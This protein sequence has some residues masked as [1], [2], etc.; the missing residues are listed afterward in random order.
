MACTLN[1]AKYLILTVDLPM[2]SN[3]KY[4][5]KDESRHCEPFVATLWGVSK[6]ITY[7][8]G[9]VTIGG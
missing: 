1:I 7:S 8:R 3:F 5:C 9:D 2:Y 6:V 4:C